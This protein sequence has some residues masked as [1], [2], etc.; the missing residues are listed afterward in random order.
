MKKIGVGM[1]ILKVYHGKIQYVRMV[2]SIFRKSYFSR[3]C[4]KV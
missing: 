2:V 4:V 3:T 1:N